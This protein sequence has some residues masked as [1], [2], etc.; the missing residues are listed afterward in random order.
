VWPS[1]LC[2]KAESL[3]AS[4]RFLLKRISARGCTGRPKQSAPPDARL[5][6][7]VLQAGALDRRSARR[8]NSW[9]RSVSSR[10]FT[11]PFLFPSSRIERAESRR[12][13]KTKNWQTTQWTPGGRVRAQPFGASMASQPRTPPEAADLFWSRC[14]GGGKVHC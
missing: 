1:R 3:P 14:L 11:R 12:E 8:A 6:R 4:T 2:P 7:R 5:V 10:D 9:T 13:N